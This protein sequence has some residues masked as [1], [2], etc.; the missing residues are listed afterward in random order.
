MSAALLKTTENTDP[1]LPPPTSPAPR[2]ELAQ[3]GRGTALVWG[4]VVLLLLGA[5][6][7]NSLLTLSSLWSTD[8]SYSHGFLVPLL[9]AWLAWRAYQRA[10]A[11]VAGDVRVGS[12]AILAGCV[13]HLVTLILAWPPLDF[14]ALGLVLWGVAVT[15]GGAEWARGFLFPIGFLFF[16]FPLPV[17]WT[18][19]VALWLQDWVAGV[20]A[21]LLDLFT[22]CYRRGNSLYL[23]GLRDP[24]VVAAECSGLRQIVAFVALGVLVG[25]LSGKSATFRV[26]LAVAAVPVAIAANVARI[27]L[28]AAGA[29]WFGTGW[30]GGWM[31]DTPALVTVPLGLCLFV[32]VGW[33]LARLP[34]VGRQSGPTAEPE[35]SLRDKEGPSCP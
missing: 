17:Q 28:M 13:V 26:L 29:L 6:F 21:G 25:G 9:S 33:G 3:V 11:P 1:G 12:M 31:H 4:V 20:S 10:G 32:L 27:L 22:V 24:L 30:M 15:A 7:G 5:L 2:A 19:Y 14:P 8:P 34:G 23:S 16:M 18:A 35:R